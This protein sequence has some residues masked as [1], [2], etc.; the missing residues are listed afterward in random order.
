MQRN[1]PAQIHTQHK[2]MQRCKAC[3]WMAFL[4]IVIETEY[5]LSGEIYDC[6]VSLCVCLPACMRMREIYGKIIWLLHCTCTPRCLHK[7]RER[8]REREHWTPSNEN[9]MAVEF[10]FSMSSVLVVVVVCLLSCYTL[11]FTYTVHCTAHTIIHTYMVIEHFNTKSR[12]RL[13]IR[14]FRISLWTLHALSVSLLMFSLDSELI[15]WTKCINLHILWPLKTLNRSESR[16]SIYRYIL[17]V[18]TYA[19]N[20]NRLK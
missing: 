13:F 11:E 9:D 3:V 1:G 12:R 4:R 10:S 14:V 8:E 17:H 5:W 7:K 6:V 20:A 2:T 16:E 15:K 18:H 19:C